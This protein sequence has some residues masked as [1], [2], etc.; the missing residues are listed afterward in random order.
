VFSAARA[1]EASVYVVRVLVRVREVLAAHH[2]PPM[3]EIGAVP[4]RARNKSPRPIL[5]NEENTRRSSRPI[6]KTIGTS[7]TTD[8]RRHSNT[9]HALSI[10]KV[11]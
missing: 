4:H 6:H 11:G 10:H 1:I 8:H 2:F 3:H 5:I 7:V 9:A